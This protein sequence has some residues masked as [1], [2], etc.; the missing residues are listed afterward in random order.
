MIVEYA[1]M[2]GAYWE[3][4]RAEIEPGEINGVPDVP[5]VFLVWAAEGAP[6]LARTARLRRRLNRLIRAGDQPSRLLNLVGLARRIEYWKCG[7]RLETSILFYTLARKHYPDQYLKLAKLRMPAYVKLMLGN[8]FPRTSVTTRLGGGRGLPFGPFRT[9]L[10]A[11][12]FEAQAL[13][14]FQ[15]RRCQENLEPRPDHPGCIYGEMSM[16][17]R[18]CQ[19][20]VGASEY[21]SE[22]RRV[23]EFLS[24]GGSSLLESIGAARERSSEEMDFEEAARQHKR[25]ERVEQVL[26]LR[27]ELCADAFSLTGAAVTPSPVSGCVVLWFF[28][29]GV[30]AQPALFSVAPDGTGLSLDHRLREAFRAA[31]PA[32]ATAAERQE[33]LALLAAWFYS[34]WRDGEWVRFEKAGTPPYRRLV[35]AIS[36]IAKGSFQPQH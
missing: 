11:E 5:A 16:C 2:M 33:H 29:D 20:V 22:V 10:A 1:G 18:P 23:E 24:S 31:E 12:Q 14:L 32:R 34:S 15:I 17:L 28:I 3:Q 35:N 9:R 25:Y 27:D 6:Y 13:D 36:R 19:Q 30:W 21:A 8:E 26:K 4:Q 7:S